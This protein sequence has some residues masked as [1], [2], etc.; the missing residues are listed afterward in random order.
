MNR[1]CAL[2]A[3]GAISAWIALAGQGS[4]RQWKRGAGGDLLI[5]F[6]GQDLGSGEIAQMLAEQLRKGL[7]DSGA[8]VARETNAARLAGV[9]GTAQPGFAV[10]AYDIALQMYRGEGSFKAA[11]PIDLRVLVENYKY[12][13]LCRSDFGRDQAYLVVEALMKNAELL[14]LTVPA[15]SGDGIPPHPGALAFVKASGIGNK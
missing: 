4:D 8:R 7:P 12:Q 5:H 9:L 3:I 15:T 6:N 13:L 2:S 1:R 11:G 10:M 14:K